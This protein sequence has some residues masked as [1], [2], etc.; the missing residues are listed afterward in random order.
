M[1]KRI[2]IVLAKCKDCQRAKDATHITRPPLSPIIPKRLRH[3]AATDLM[4][5]LPRTNQGNRYIL[6]VIELTS[7]YT[8]LTPLKRATGLSVSKA[9]ERNFIR[10]VGR[11]E[12]IISDNGSQYRSEVWRATLRR[13]KIKPIFIPRY[14]PS[15]NVAERCMKD[16]G[17]WCRLYTGRRHNSWDE[18]LQ[19]L[20]HIINEIPHTTTGLPPVTVLKNVQPADRIRETVR[21]PSHRQPP[22][23]LVIKD[24]LK[25]IELAAQRRKTRMDKNA[26]SRIFQVGDRVLVKTHP[27]ASKSEKMCIKFFARY[28]GPMEITRLIHRNTVELVD[29]R[30]GKHLGKHHVSHL[31]VYKE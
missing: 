31:K 24:A 14:K 6:V 30:N 15:T 26:C 12:R 20:Q 7:K 27:R 28:R 11:V 9:L 16:I 13:L 3:L 8:T 2:R 22:H 1:E 4:G 23:H 25:K 29:P 18:K 19:E 10:Q 17:T 21:F 5:P